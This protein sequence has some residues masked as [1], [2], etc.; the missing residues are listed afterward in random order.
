MLVW[1]DQTL[2]ETKLRISQP[3]IFCNLRWR[4]LFATRETVFCY[5]K[6]LSHFFWADSSV[7]KLHSWLAA[8]SVE[9]FHDRSHS[10]PCLHESVSG[11]LPDSFS[12]NVPVPSKGVSTS[13]HRSSKIDFSRWSLKIV[14][15][16]AHAPDLSEW[17]SFFQDNLQLLTGLAFYREH[18]LYVDRA[19]LFHSVTVSS[20]RRV[21]TAG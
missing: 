11:F 14:F 10:H 21:S 19:D 15:S 3:I 13:S 2:E 7:N 1:S 16:F 17:N 9:Q 12:C 18:P 5:R 8:I 6:F 4:Y 20:F